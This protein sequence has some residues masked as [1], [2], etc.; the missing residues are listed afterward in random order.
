[1]IDNIKDPYKD[2]FIFPPDEDPKPKPE[3]KPEPKPKSRRM[4]F[5]EELMMWV[6]VE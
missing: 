6:S 1:M 5:D 4:F 2:F 3:P